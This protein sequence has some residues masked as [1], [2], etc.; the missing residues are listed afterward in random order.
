MKQIPN[1]LQAKASARQIQ[2]HLF[3]N[4]STCVVFHYHTSI[5]LILIGK[6]GSQKHTIHKNTCEHSFTLHSQHIHLTFI[7]LDT[8]ICRSDRT[9]HLAGRR[10]RYMALQLTS[11]A[12]GAR[13][14]RIQDFLKVEPETLSMHNVQ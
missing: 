9:L 14:G 1:C 13:Q 4:K 6:F 2:I 11:E 10:S 5:N 3:R 7:D 12:G 8:T